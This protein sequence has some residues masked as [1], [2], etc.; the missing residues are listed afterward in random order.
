MT[1]LLFN[2]RVIRVLSK[3]PRK[4][5]IDQHL[6]ASITPINVGFTIEEEPAISA[7]E[8]RKAWRKVFKREAKNKKLA[9]EAVSFTDVAEF[10]KDIFANVDPT[11]KG[12]FTPGF[13]Y[14]QNFSLFTM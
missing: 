10:T 7:V 5:N 14:T 3:N 9:R 1:G 13:Q 6:N 4:K 11:N 12:Y 8:F 2:E